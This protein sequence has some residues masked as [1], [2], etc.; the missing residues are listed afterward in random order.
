MPSPATY[1]DVNLI[2]KLYELRRE[3]KMREARVWFYSSFFPKSLAEYQELCPPGSQTSAYARMVVSYWEM[4]ASFVTSGVLNAELLF[5]SA[6]EMLTVWE[7]V[8]P[9]VAEF[10]AVTKSAMPYRNL[11]IVG[12]N[13]ITFVKRSGEGAYERFSQLINTPPQKGP[14]EEGGQPKAS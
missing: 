1:D 4:V 13:Y 12:D 8:R 5:Q 7:R 3:D 2:L 10:R 11:E 6:Q 14:A 9:M